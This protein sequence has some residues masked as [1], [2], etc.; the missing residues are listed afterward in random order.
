MGAPTCQQ[1]GVASMQ[2][3]FTLTQ[4]YAGL[5][6]GRRGPGGS[7][8]TVRAFAGRPGCC[9]PSTVFPHCKVRRK[10]ASVRSCPLRVGSSGACDRATAAE[11][12][13]SGHRP[14]RSF[15]YNGGF[16]TF[17]TSRA[18][19]AWHRNETERGAQWLADVNIPEAPGTGAGIAIA[20]ELGEYRGRPRSPAA[21]LADL[22]LGSGRT[23]VALSRSSVG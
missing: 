22:G 19:G 18:F 23:P 14:A 15:R 4:R 12:H 21:G 8:G 16:T 7:R 3:V 6:P 10:L 9:I 13:L 11:H 2:C 17:V 5:A 20:R 1:G